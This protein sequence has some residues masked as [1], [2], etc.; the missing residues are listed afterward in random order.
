MHSTGILNSIEKLRNYCLVSKSLLPKFYWILA[1]IRNP[2]GNILSLYPRE[3]RSQPTPHSSSPLHFYICRRLQILHHM[4]LFRDSTNHS[5]RDLT[6]SIHLQE[7]LTWHTVCSFQGFRKPPKNSILNTKA[8][9]ELNLYLRLHRPPLWHK[10]KISINFTSY[11]Q[12]CS[13]SAFYTYS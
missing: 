6:A 9:E 3:F 10:T 5:G 7:S 2:E 4:S 8:W 1:A 13:P 12:Q 11:M